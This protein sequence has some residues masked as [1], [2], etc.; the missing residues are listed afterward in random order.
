MTRAL[1]FRFSVVA[2]M[3][4][5]LGAG[6]GWLGCA[7]STTPN[8][9]GLDLGEAS[10]T[11]PESGTTLLRVDEEGGTGSAVYYTDGDAADEEAAISRFDVETEDG[12]FVVTVNAAGDPTRVEF[13]NLV[14]TFTAHDDGTMDFTCTLDGETVYGATGVTIEDSAGISRAHPRRDTAAPTWPTAPRG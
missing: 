10:L 9:N 14:I 7:T 13:G 6:L 11:I 1:A 8:D 12:T 3:A 4:A 5:T 2:V